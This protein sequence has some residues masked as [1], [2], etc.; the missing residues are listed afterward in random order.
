MCKCPVGR[1]GTHCEF[2]QDHQFEECS[3]DCAR[4][5]CAKGFKDYDYLVGTGPFPASLL[6]I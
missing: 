4:G 1:T 6:P 2:S 5:V 3:L